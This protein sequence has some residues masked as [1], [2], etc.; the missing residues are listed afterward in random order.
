MSLQDRQRISTA[1]RYP[2]NTAG[3]LMNTDTI[4]VRARYSVDVVLRYLR[5]HHELPDMTDQIFV[6]NRK[7]EFIGVL[8]I[9]KI[10]VSDPHNTVREIMLTNAEALPASMDDV[11]IAQRFES[12]RLG[13][14]TRC[15]RTR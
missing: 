1:L 8:P 15:R 9:A 3:G 4:T 12:A 2:D 13:F 7:D 5:R 14:S 10:L 11:D 6:V